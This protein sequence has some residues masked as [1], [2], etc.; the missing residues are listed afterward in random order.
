MQ[1]MKNRICNRESPSR[2]IMCHGSHPNNANIAPRLFTLQKSF[3]NVR[4]PSSDTQNDTPE[5]L[6]NDLFRRSKSLDGFADFFL[7]Q[8]LPIL[9]C[10]FI[11]RF[12]VAD[13]LV[14]HS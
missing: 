11:H 10:D 8:L 9:S 12:D 7:G 4:D 14:K 5:K 13:F 1:T 3:R 2:K 6:S